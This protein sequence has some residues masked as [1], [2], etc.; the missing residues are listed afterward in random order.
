MTRIRTRRT[1]LASRACRHA[2]RP[3]PRDGFAYK[4][5]SNEEMFRPAHSL[6]VL[7]YRNACLYRDMFK[8]VISLGRRF[9]PHVRNRA[10]RS[11]AGR[12]SVPRRLGTRAGVLHAK[13]GDT[14]EGDAEAEKARLRARRSSVV[15]G[16]GE[17][18]PD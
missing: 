9:V 10:V 17:C 3:P 11:V 12:S 7:Q 13:R 16:W 2:G 14:R 1:L 8:S 4:N 6:K 5:I 18:G 15:M